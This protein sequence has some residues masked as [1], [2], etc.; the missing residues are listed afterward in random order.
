MRSHSGVAAK[1]FETLAKDGIE[2]MAVSTS[3]IKISCVIDDR[4]AELAVRSLHDT[5]GLAK[6]P[7]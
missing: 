7:N 2:V 6:E 3:D 1:M 4:Y 5:F